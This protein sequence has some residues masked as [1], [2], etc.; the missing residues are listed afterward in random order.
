MMRF[1]EVMRET[2]ARGATLPADML[3]AAKST[4]IRKVILFRY[5][6]LQVSPLNLMIIFLQ[7]PKFV[8]K[9]SCSKGG[10]LATRCRDQVLFA[11]S[12]SNARRPIIS[13]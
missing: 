7:I 8:V 12:E 5:L 13:F 11:A 4:G 2:E 6:D 9:V 10:A 3:E 1:E